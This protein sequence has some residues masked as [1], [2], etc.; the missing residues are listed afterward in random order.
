M[1]ES[2]CEGMLVKVTNSNVTYTDGTAAPITI[3]SAGPSST[4]QGGTLTDAAGYSPPK[5]PITVAQNETYTFTAGSAEGTNG[6]AG[7]AIVIQCMYASSA[8]IPG[9]PQTL[10]VNYTGTCAI[11]NSNNCTGAGTDSVASSNFS[12]QGSS[13]QG[14]GS[15]CTVTFTVMNGGTTG[16]G[17]T[18][19]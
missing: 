15:D 1:T 8:A 14:K 10:T 17:T 4:G 16:T 9:T 5:V 11:I 7:G 18:T 2:A 3:T 6:N 19:S 13:T 12:A